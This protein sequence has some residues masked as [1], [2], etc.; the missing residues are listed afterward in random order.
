MASWPSI[1]L[2][3]EVATGETN[4]GDQLLPR[5]EATTATSGI[6]IRT[7]TADAGDAYAKLFG[8]LERRGIEGLIPTKAE[9]IR[10]PVPLRRF[11]DEARHDRV[12]RPRGKVLR[13]GQPVEHG[14]CFHARPRDGSR[15][16][17]VALGV[18][19]GRRAKSVVIGDDD[20]ALLRA[21]RRRERWSHDD[22][23]LYQRHRWRAEGDHGEAKTW[24]GLARAV[25]RGLETM[26][27][28]AFLTAAAVHLQRLAA[29]LLELWRRRITAA[30]IP[31]G[32]RHQPRARS[33][34]GRL[35][36]ASA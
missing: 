12:V 18:A 21:R 3:V 2:D 5:L 15:C 13:A 17:L 36:R 9:P 11:R 19:K 6:A 4:A 23:R 34:D 32:D 22:D 10:S 25:R 1:V 28:Q 27:I 30:S 33:F 7:V 35:C 31:Y 16:D 14:R 26:R 20:P 8:G 29:T 24:H